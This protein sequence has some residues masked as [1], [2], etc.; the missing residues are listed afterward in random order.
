MMKNADTRV[1]KTLSDTN[2][3]RYIFDNDLDTDLKT[4]LGL[5]AG[6]NRHV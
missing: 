2:T 3:K 4:I 5:Y 1:A 6:L